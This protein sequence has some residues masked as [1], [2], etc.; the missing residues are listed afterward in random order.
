MVARWT[1]AELSLI[2]ARSLSINVLEYFMA[3]YA[4][5][6]AGRSLAGR[7]VGCLIDNTTAM[8]WLGAG[9][10]SSHSVGGRELAKL[11]SLYC[12]Q[13]NIFITPTYINTH[14]NVL[15]DDLSRDVSLQITA[16]NS[17]DAGTRDGRWWKGFTRQDI[18]RTL[19]T[20]SV[21][22]PSSTPLPLLLELLAHLL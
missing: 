18:L 17:L 4:I 15:A 3:I 22:Y 1:D 13:L 21:S 9:R 2:S 19:L 16:G 7:V 10:A 8:S 5:M 12:I 20:R 11:F 14:R 6:S